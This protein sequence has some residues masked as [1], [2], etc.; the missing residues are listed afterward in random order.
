MKYA[1][2]DF[3]ELAIAERLG[4][5]G[6]SGLC[7]GSWCWRDVLAQ[8]GRN[9]PNVLHAKRLGGAETLSEKERG[10]CQNGGVGKRGER[11]FTAC[12]F[13]SSTMQS[14]TKMMRLVR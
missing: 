2:F 1:L 4:V 12:V 14:S 6:V 8:S 7:A 10:R 9:H 3:L 5:G 11:W 13:K